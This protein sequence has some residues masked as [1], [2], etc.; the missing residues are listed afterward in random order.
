MITNKLYI[1]PNESG[2]LR[3]PH[4][5]FFTLLTRCQINETLTITVK[6]IIDFKSF[7][8][9]MTRKFIITFFNIFVNLVA[10]ETR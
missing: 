8:S 4:I 7:R 3:I 9:N 5:K 10:V 2:P 6:I 1:S